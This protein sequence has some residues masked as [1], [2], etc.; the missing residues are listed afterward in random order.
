MCEPPPVYLTGGGSLVKKGQ[1]NKGMETIPRKEKVRY[2]AT[3]YFHFSLM[4]TLWFQ[5]PSFLSNK[6]EQ[7]AQKTATLCFHKWPVY[8]L[9][10]MLFSF[11]LEWKMGRCIPA[12]F[13]MNEKKQAWRYAV[14]TTC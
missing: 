3:L 13:L 9:S 7:K 1:A 5:R 8:K 12:H 2:L 6:I 4:A 11:G 14:F 10:H